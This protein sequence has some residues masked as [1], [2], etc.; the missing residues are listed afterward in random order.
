MAAPTPPQVELSVD[1]LLP[2]G[3]DFDDDP[4]ARVRKMLATLCDVHFGT[5]SGSSAVAQP[6][7]EGIDS[8]ALADAWRVARVA[9]DDEDA[10]AAREAQI[11]QLLSLAYSSHEEAARSLLPAPLRGAR[12]GAAFLAEKALK[13]RRGGRRAAEAAE[14]HTPGSAGLHMGTSLGCLEHIGRALANGA[15]PGKA[16]A[17]VAAQVAA[18]KEA[19]AAAAAAAEQARKMAAYKQRK[20]E[21]K[22]EREGAAE[23]GARSHAAAEPPADTEALD[24]RTQRRMQKVLDDLQ[25]PFDVAVDF[26]DKYVS[27]A[28][29][30]E[31]LTTALP[32]WEEAAA[33]M[34]KH[35]ALVRRGAGDEAAAARERCLAAARALEAVG[36][37]ASFQGQPFGKLLGSP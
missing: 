32:L 22:E 18:A 27:G 9:A 15:N 36:D 2:T 20:A 10:I 7:P 37:V 8:H 19:A 5:L 28:Q 33:A 4:E 21:E 25:A 3:T 26:A 13:A 6:A 35:R 24:K 14:D 1:E 12:S 29:D 16:R 30:P 34:L 11:A 23:G 31:A 17:A